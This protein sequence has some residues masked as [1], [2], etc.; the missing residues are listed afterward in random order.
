MEEEK[1]GICRVCL[2][3]SKKY[4]VVDGDQEDMLQIVVPDM[5]RENWHQNLF[6]LSLIFTEYSHFQDLKIC[7]ES[8][9]CYD[10]CCALQ[11]TFSFKST[12][13]EIEDTIHSYTNNGQIQINL[14]KI[15]GLKD[16]EIND[17]IEKYSKICRTCLNVTEPL[18]Y[19]KLDNNNAFMELEMMQYYL[20]EVVSQVKIFVPNID[21]H[22]FVMIGLVFLPSLTSRVVIFV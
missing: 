13:L 12:C 5:V 6:L 22:F 16:L 17:M 11:E 19:I 20:P 9:I 8:Y 7:R 18:S 2:S 1:T 10:C 3:F 14:D 15:T 4:D 21:K